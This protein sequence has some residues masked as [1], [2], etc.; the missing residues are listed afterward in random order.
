LKLNKNTIYGTFFTRPNGS[1]TRKSILRLGL[2][3]F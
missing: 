2:C 3:N 1:F